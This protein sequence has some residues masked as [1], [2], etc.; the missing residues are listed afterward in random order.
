MSLRIE[1]EMTVRVIGRPVTQEI[2]LAKVVEKLQGGTLTIHPR[3]DVL[4][5]HVALLTGKTLKAH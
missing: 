5:N 1:I 4:R 2:V 3:A